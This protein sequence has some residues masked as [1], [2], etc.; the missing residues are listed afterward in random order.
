LDLAARVLTGRAWPDGQANEAP[1]QPV[2]ILDTEGCQAVWCQRAAQWGLADLP[3][4]FPGDGLTRVPLE[5]G[6][7]PATV[8]E[9]A[10]EAGARLV[11]I[12]SLRA[13]LGGAVDENDSRVA[14]HLANWSEMARSE[15]VAILCVH[16]FRKRQAGGANQALERLRGSSAIGAAAR[17]VIAVQRGGDATLV[18][19]VKSNLGTLPPPLSFRWAD[20]RL[21]WSPGVPRVDRR[22]A[23]ERATD[24]L[25]P[26]LVRAP[27]AAGETELSEILERTRDQCS[28]R[29]LYEARDYLR[30]EVIQKDGRTYWRLPAENVLGEPEA[31]GAEA[32]DAGEE[33]LPGTEAEPADRRHS[34]ERN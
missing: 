24:L 1:G 10:A 34:V 12:D 7:S 17:S 22:A 20:N 19:V 29:A 9:L 26:L 4:M 30:L 32:P 25:R 28:R 6:D 16:H 31:P 11:I 13:G 21:V 3:L 2:L 5:D 8:A 33:G 23:Y 18:Q 14:A 15:S 27:G